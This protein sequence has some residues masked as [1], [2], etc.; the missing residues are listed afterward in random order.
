L[1]IP[2]Y[3]P[4]WDSDFDLPYFYKRFQAQVISRKFLKR[5]LRDF[6]TVA[7]SE[8]CSIKKE[9]L[10]SLSLENSVFVRNS[11]ELLEESHKVSDRIRPILAY[12]AHQQYVGFFIY[13]LFKYPKTTVSSGH[14]LSIIW[15]KGK[16]TNIENVSIEFH[17]SGFFRRLV[18]TF[19]ILRHPNAYSSWLPIQREG[20]YVF[21]EN[22]LDSRIKIGKVDLPSMM[23]YNSKPFEE[24][25]CQRFPNERVYPD[26]YDKLL[27]N[28]CLL[29]VASNIARYRPQLW[30]RIL[31][32]LSEN[33]A[34]FNKRMKRVYE[35]TSV[36]ETTNVWETF[37]CQ[38]YAEFE[39]LLRSE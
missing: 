13:T 15:G 8:A 24:E 9:E 23:N 21:V 35:M 25:F 2:Q 5:T 30:E 34:M 36:G 22:N 31:E 38:I 4:Q 29:F 14:G 11:R 18:D 3:K 33:E 16:N 39:K 12:Y 32:G 17:K 7:E 37:H 28:F 27:T 19:T 26:T 10:E 6:K 1:V 20:K